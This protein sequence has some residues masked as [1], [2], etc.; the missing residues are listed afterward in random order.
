MNLEKKTQN[1]KQT[2]EIEKEYHISMT[3]NFTD[4]VSLDKG[5]LSP[6]END[7]W[8]PRRT[9]SVKSFTRSPCLV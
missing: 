2:K 9:Y 6:L 1:T 5:K 3:H 4:L 8:T 7:F